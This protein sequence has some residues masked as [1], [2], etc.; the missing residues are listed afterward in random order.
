M[1]P[2]QVVMLCERGRHAANSNRRL[3]PNVLVEEAKCTV[4]MTYCNLLLYTYIC[5]YIST[6]G[7]TCAKLF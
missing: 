5:P 7:G 2:K 4:H 1:H 3:T 6:V